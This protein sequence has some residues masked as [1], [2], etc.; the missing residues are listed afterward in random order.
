MGEACWQRE[1]VASP[2]LFCVLVFDITD[3][4]CHRFSLPRVYASLR[5]CFRV[6]GV[7]Q[8]DGVI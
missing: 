4:I 6:V 5:L 8:H 1:I 3:G 2:K 7:E